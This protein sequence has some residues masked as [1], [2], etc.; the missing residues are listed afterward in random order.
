MTTSVRT[1]QRSREVI[2]ADLFTAS[3]ASTPFVIRTTRRQFLPTQ[4]AVGITAQRLV[5]GSRAARCSD[6]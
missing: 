2:H 4:V 3:N 5:A 6:A 1:R